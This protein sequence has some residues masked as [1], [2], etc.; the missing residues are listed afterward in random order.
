MRAFEEAST[1]QV[2]QG[3]SFFPPKHVYHLADGPWKYGAS[4]HS[5]SKGFEAGGYEAECREKQQGQLAASTW[6]ASILEC[7]WKRATNVA[8]SRA[9]RE[10]R[11]GAMPGFPT[12]TSLSESKRQS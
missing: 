4:T 5:A 1:A 12:S 10:A 2:H 7:E 6:A 11:H 9:V 3:L 8:Q